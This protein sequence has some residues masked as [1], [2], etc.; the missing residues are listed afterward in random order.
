MVDSKAMRWESRLSKTMSSFYTQATATRLR[1]VVFSVLLVWAVTLGVL[2]ARM[3]PTAALGL[4]GGVLSLFASLLF[5]GLV[6]MVWDW[7][8]RRWG[9]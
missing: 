7:L 3:M 5:I 6:A 8:G 9:F 2:T 1:R 4:L